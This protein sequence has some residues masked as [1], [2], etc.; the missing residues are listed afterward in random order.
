VI[1]Q[2]RQDDALKELNAIVI[3]DAAGNRQQ[4]YFGTGGGRVGA[5]DQFEMP[6]IPPRGI[7]DA[8]Y[9]SGRFAEFAD[10]SDA[11]EIP[12][13]IS[14]ESYPISISLN[15]RITGG[16]SVSLLIDGNETNF[17]GANVAV[18]AGPLSRVVL[19]LTP[20]DVQKPADI[21]LEQNYPN[22]FNPATVIRYYLPSEEKVTLRIYDILGRVAATLVNGIE[23]GGNKSVE[24]NAVNFSSGI[25]FYRLDAVSTTDPAKSFTRTKRMFLIK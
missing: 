9:S 13:S 23:G 20:S 1:S 2:V 14:S 15:S 7:F 21:Q 6:P 22:P 16:C 4:L 19:K 10:G 12:I 18:V 25:Y 11:R 17:D 24:W 5:L 8:R 3:E